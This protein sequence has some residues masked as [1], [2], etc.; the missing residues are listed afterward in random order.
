MINENITS[1][2]SKK[3]GGLGYKDLHV[4]NL[5]MLAKQGWR[6]LVTP[7]SLCARVLKAKY[8]PDTDIFHATPKAG[9]SYAWRSILQGIEVLKKGVIKRVGD[10]TTVKIWEDPWLPRNWDRKPMTRRG[11]IILSTT[12]ELMDPHTAA[13]DE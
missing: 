5:A 4:F 13:W 8:F 6:L 12:V 3:E 10:G 7:D 1:F 9:M 2:R 11:N